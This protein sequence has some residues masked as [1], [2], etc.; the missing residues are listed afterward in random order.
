M[1][2]TKQDPIHED[3]F[4]EYLER[5]QKIDDIKF[6]QLIDDNRYYTATRQRGD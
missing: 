2:L 4:Y 1:S 5:R 3:L 6:K